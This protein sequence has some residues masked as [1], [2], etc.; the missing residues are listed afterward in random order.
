[1]T[2]EEKKELEL[3]CH[4]MRKDC[5]LMAKAA[6]NEGFHFGA[7]LSMIE[8]IAVLY[9]KVMHIGAGLFRSEERDRFILSKG[10]GVPAI[11]AVLEQMGILSKEDLGSFKGSKTFLYGH[12]SKNEELG[13]EFSAGSLGQGLSFG[14]GKALALKRKENKKSRVYVLLGDG[15]CDE[16]AIWEAVLSAVKYNLDNLVAII[17]RNHLQYDGDTEMV[18]PI[19][20]L[21]Q[22]WKAFGW[23][24]SRINGHDVEDIFV[25]LQMQH[26]KPRVVIADTVKGKGISFMENVAEWHYGIMTR[27]QEKQ[28]WK[29][30]WESG[31]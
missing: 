28:A 8:L 9:L 5:L 7:T 30:V 22:K 24:V 16:G 29:E 18:M 27:E 15:E 13:I 3:H 25:N 2:T 12:P 21:E 11:Y 14:V 23:D 31:D 1:M 26:A 17:D 6:G 10:H 4:E 20:F 19:E